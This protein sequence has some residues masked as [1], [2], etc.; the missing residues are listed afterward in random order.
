MWFIAQVQ[1]LE[2]P[3]AMKNKT[4]T[5]VFLVFPYKL[6]CS[7]L[8]SFTNIF[9]FSSKRD[10]R[11]VFAKNSF[12]GESSPKSNL[13]IRFWVDD[14]IKFKQIAS[15]GK[16]IAL[17]GRVPIFTVLL[18]LGVG[19]NAWGQTASTYT[20][21]ASSS[22]WTALASASNFTFQTSAT[23]D[24]DYSNAV[25]IPFTFTFC[26][27][28]YTSCFVSTN[29]WLKFGSHASPQ[30]A[31]YINSTSGFVNIR[32]AVFPL[33]DDL[34]NFAGTT[35]KIDGT[36]PNRIFKAQWNQ[37]W[38]YSA[39]ASVI[40]MQVWLHETTNVVEFYYNQGSALVS[41]GSASI[42]I[43]DG[44]SNYLSLNSSGI[45]PTASSSTFT[46]NISAKPANGQKYTFTPC[47]ALTTYYSK[48]TGNL[49]VL[50]NWGT[51]SDGSGCNPANFT[52][53]GIT[54]IVQNNATPT[55]SVSGWA[56]SGAGSIV[57]VGNGSSAITFSAAGSLSFDC[58]LEITGNAT[59]SLGSNSMTL[60]GDLVRSAATAG[61]SQTAA[62]ASTVTFSGSSQEV[63]V[64]ALNGTTA[65]D[66]DITFNHVIISG[67]SVKLFYLKTNDRKLNIN[68]FTV[69][70]GAVVTLYSNPL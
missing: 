28:G 32:P 35:Y 48:S 49:D 21:S 61:L 25:T 12:V 22:T 9:S 39:N 69:N 65:T 51:S 1:Y 54:Y 29:G 23:G 55:T 57:K 5:Q 63:N 66:S 17:K 37:E 3:Y 41:S 24:E 50:T 19:G 8:L 34:Q 67:S 13:L 53:A 11:G 15:F 47:S 59:L 26:G 70:V 44:S 30:S 60:S 40:L 27:T 56:V 18:A 42:G 33:W 68:N 7:F 10:E 36:S 20:F 2:M 58:N 62:S 31:E 4:F 52:T 45:S 38:S 6:L 64:T 46:T 14:V 43:A 16:L